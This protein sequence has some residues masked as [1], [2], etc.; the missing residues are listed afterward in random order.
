MLINLRDRRGF[1]LAIS[2]I[3]ILVLGLFVL[4]GLALLVGGGIDVFKSSTKPFF[5][6]TS[7]SSIKQACQL[8]CEGRDRITYCCKKYDIDDEKVGCGDR[9]L[10]IQCGLECR[11]FQCEG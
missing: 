11:D 2:T 4:I 5:D 9:R 3:V 1:E 6:T 8:A 10:E 7:V